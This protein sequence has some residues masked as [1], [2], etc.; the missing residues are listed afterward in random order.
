MELLEFLEQT[1]LATFIRESSSLLAFPTVLFLHTLG[2]SLVVGANSLVAIRVLGVA[3]SIPLQPLARLFPFMWVGFIFTVISGAGLA[4][5][6]ATT[7]MLNPILLVKLVLIVFAAVIMWL[8][9]KKV[10]RNPGGLKRA[11]PGD[12]RMMAA[13]LLILWTVVMVAGRLIAY[14]STIFGT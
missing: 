5:A 12:G 10:F 13:A 2:L 9:E 6:K 4:M 1:A 11:E 14:S 8:L 3:S 7:L